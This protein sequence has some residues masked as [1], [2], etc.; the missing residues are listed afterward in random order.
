M[1]EQ[2]Q[3]EQS[4]EQVTGR[5]QNMTAGLA[6][7]AYMIVGTCGSSFLTVAIF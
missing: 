4:K 6:G 5:R 1:Q 7:A 3:E 2:V